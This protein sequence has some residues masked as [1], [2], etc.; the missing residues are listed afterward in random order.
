MMRIVRKSE[1]D[2]AKKR[3]GWCGKARWMVRKR[4]M[5][6]A[7]QARVGAPKITCLGLHPA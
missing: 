3:D 4:E 2:G 7:E 5:D 6:G 1:M